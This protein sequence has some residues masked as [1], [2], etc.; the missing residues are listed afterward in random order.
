MNYNEE[1]KKLLTAFRDD[2]IE[3]IYTALL[4]L[5]RMLDDCCVIPDSTNIMA[6]EM[7]SVTKS[8]IKMKIN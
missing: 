5:Q 2:K 8:N 3:D 7:L 1:I 6:D 4:N